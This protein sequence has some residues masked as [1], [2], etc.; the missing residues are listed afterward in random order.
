MN[1][2]SITKSA[3]N[4]PEQEQSPF[5]SVIMPVHNGSATLDRA[6]ESVISQTLPNWEL[7]A[8]D[9]AS[10]DGSGETLKSW[11]DKD[12]RINLIF[13]KEHSGSSVAR[14]IAL[15][16]ARG[17][18]IAYL[19]QY[20]EY[21]AD[22]LEQVFAQR[23]KGDLLVFGYDFAEGDGLRTEIDRPSSECKEF[24]AVGWSQ[25]S[26]LQTA[27]TVLQQQK[28]SEPWNPARKWQNIFVSNVAASLAVAHRCSLLEK[29]EGFHDLLW[30]NE[31][32]DLWKR[33]ARAGVKFFFTSQKS[34]RFHI[35]PA[36]GSCSPRP[37]PRQLEVV[38]SNYR[39]GKPIF[40]D[41]P[42]LPAPHP[43][44]KVAF[45]SPHC[46][47][48]FTNGAATATL[49]GLQLLHSLGFG[50]HVLCSSQSDAWE[51]VVLE[52]VLAKQKTPYEVRDIRLG[53]HAAQILLTHQK[54]IPFSI[55]KKKTTTRQWQDKEEVAT[56]LAACE[57]LLQKN[58]PDVI[59]TY[60]GDPV[61]R[62]IH[63]LAKKLDIPIVFYL[64]NFAYLSP[65]PF[66]LMDYV[67]V[68]SQFAR[69]FYWEKIGLACQV[70][71]L[72]LNTERTQVTE[73]NPQY[74]T[75]V[76]PEPRKGIHVF[77]RIAE[78]LSARRPDIPMLVVE[79]ISRRGLLHKLGVDLSGI[80]NLK[81]M[82]NTPDPRNFYS[83]TKL[84]LMPSLME[85]VGFAAME[86]MLNGISVLASNRG[87]LPE[88]M[89]SDGFMF[90]IPAK[91]TTQTREIPSAEEVQPWVDAIV[92]LW[93]DKAFYEKSSQA[94]RQRAQRWLP[95]QLAPVYKD[96]FSRIFNQP[97]P[98][99]APQ[100]FTVAQDGRA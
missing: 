52:D 66:R 16:H 68:P 17:E 82:A 4:M 18:F 28:P 60:G 72:V 48:D 5:V 25:I 11:A 78:M 54:E 87:A 30:E 98:P 62:A 14:N 70:L 44:R 22:Y 69:R 21:Y 32:W 65:D 53:T 43:V 71:P 76:N 29:A 63:R 84:L 95:E 86:A 61:S 35:R 34:G 75:F 92:R 88:T 50:C 15:R 13:V 12:R 97:G 96:F 100:P 42:K 41:R 80:K 56:F 90:D 37:A 38:L 57:F 73:W 51:E 2:S 7:L 77:A 81:I 23:D 93:D 64:H 83:V 47:L 59:W 45:V 6:I 89:G 79:G 20:D 10:T 26:T 27:S 55:F 3:Q 74:L 91:Y 9:D 94:A 1:N 99:L 33:M 49:D 67:L 8:V 40:G 46:L 19:D 58:R 85:N 39:S 31:D 36:D 24:S